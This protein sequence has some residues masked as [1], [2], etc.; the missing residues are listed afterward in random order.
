MS[1]FDAVNYFESACGNFGMRISDRNLQQIYKIC[2][3]SCPYETGG[4]LIGRYSDDLKWA[5]ITTITG[6]PANSKR[7]RFAF[8]RSNKGIIS[9][10]KKLWDEHRYYLGEWHYHPNASPLPSLTDAKTMH[11]LSK[12]ERLHCPE[13]ILLI[14]GGNPFNWHEYVGVWVRGK[15]IELCRRQ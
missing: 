11:E 7:A 10:L 5:E 3:D 15:E 2:E 13:P 6:P 1:K 9:L 8:V 4:I 14:V 12:S